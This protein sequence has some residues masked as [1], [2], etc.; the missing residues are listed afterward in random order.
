MGILARIDQAIQV[1]HGPVENKTQLFLTK[2]VVC[3]DFGRLLKD[4]II[5]TIL[6]LYLFINDYG[7]PG[8]SLPFGLP[9]QSTSILG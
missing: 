1:P 8:I 7:D 5:V 9:I 4:L 2:Y 6:I 3:L